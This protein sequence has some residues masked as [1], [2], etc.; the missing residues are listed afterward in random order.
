MSPTDATAAPAAPAGDGYPS[1]ALAWA[2]V[3]VLFIAYIFSF[4][5][6]MIIGLLIE[7]LKADLGLTDTQVSLLQGFAFA[8]FYTIVGLPLGRLIDRAS[9]MRIVAA[10]VAFWSVMTASCGLATQYWQLFL[11]RMGVGVGEATLS[12]AAYSIISDSFPQRRLGL[13]MGVYGLGSAV[14]AGLAF[15][16]GAVVIELISTA[17]SLTLPLFGELRA[18]QA[19]FVIVGLPGILIAG[20]FL[21]LP[22][23]PRHGAATATPETQ[24]V[25]PIS[26]VWRFTLTRAGAI[27]NLCFAVAMVNLAVFAAVSWLPAFLIRVHEFPLTT[28]GH[29]AGGT[30]ILGGLIGLIGGGWLSD[31]LSGGSASGR[32]AFCAVTSSIGTVFAL[33]FPLVGHPV[34]T[35]IGFTI[36]FASS[37][38]PIGA[39]ASALQQLVPNRMRATLSAVYLFIVNLIGLG[40]GPTAAALVGDTFFP[41]PDGIRYAIAIVSPIS[42]LIAAG[43]FFL[44]ARYTKRHESA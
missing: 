35:G 28:A 6:R 17:G 39:G 11:A 20:L 34:L 8:I 3:A 19:T 43:L 38:V 37:A 12:P 4:I 33:I 24:A 32:L 22:E 42:S 41:T 27:I 30:L 2:M 15:L 7:P 40:L 13:A 18:W 9:R 26:E 23:P 16:I 1:P 29:F 21:I 44:S 36:F 31:R 5:D 10:G 14:G 25:I